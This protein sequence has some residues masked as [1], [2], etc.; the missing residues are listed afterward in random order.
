[1]IHI[2]I[3]ILCIFHSSKFQI[4]T[5][6]MNTSLDMLQLCFFPFTLT[7]INC[8]ILW[9]GINTARNGP[10]QVNSSVSMENE[11][12][13]KISPVYAELFKLRWKYKQFC[14]A[15]HLD[16][17]TSFS[18]PIFTIVLIYVSLNWDALSA[19]FSKL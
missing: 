10:T 4:N 6:V 11:I 13:V 1:M 18:K 5:Y 12:R 16:I 15:S 3:D 9:L 7:E 17:S 19:F 2:I 14:L 8:S